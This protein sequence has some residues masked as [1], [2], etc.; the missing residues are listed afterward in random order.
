MVRVV[1]PM[2]SSGNDIELHPRW[3]VTERIEPATF[4]PEWLL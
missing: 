2:Y 4:R 1:R 3:L